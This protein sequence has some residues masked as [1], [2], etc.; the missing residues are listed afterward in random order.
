MVK[1]VPGL[2]GAEKTRAPLWTAWKFRT[3]LVHCF[4][5]AG[6]KLGPALPCRLRRIHAR[7]K[8]SLFEKISPALVAIVGSLLLFQAAHGDGGTV[9]AA[10]DLNYPT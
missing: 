5:L 2:F 7:L 9:L 6:F 3:G 4:G 8:F 1:A 10:D